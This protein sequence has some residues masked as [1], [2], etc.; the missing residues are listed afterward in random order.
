MHGPGRVT[1]LGGIIIDPTQLGVGEPDQTAD[2]TITLYKAPLSD[3]ILTLLSSDPY[4]CRVSPDSVTLDSDNWHTGLTLTVSPEDE[5]I[6]DGTQT[7]I[8]TTSPA[9]STDTYYS[10]IDPPDIT[11]T[12]TDDDTPLA[13]RAVLPAFGP[14]SQDM[15]TVL[16]GSGFTENTEITMRQRDENGDVTGNNQEASSMVSKTEHIRLWPFMER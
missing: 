9:V 5:D 15:A 6:A 12:V 4:E 13:L 16:R 8:I 7:C 11:V 14:A 10:G 3:V 1:Q 2:V